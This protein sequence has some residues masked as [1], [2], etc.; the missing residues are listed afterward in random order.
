[1]SIT[2][3]SA[4]F[5][6]PSRKL[7]QL[8]A[9]RRAGRPIHATDLRTTKFYKTKLCP[10]MQNKRGGGRCSEGLDCGYAHAL[11]ELRMAPNLQ[12]TKWCAKVVNGQVCT[13]PKCGYAHCAAELQSSTD[14]QT[15]KT[16]LCVFWSRNP[17]LCLNGSKCRFAH[18]EADLRKRPDLSPRKASP[19][20]HSSPHHLRSWGADSSGRSM[21]PLPRVLKRHSPARRNPA[22]C[23]AVPGAEHG[24]HAELKSSRPT[25]VDR[26]SSDEWQHGT[27]QECFRAKETWQPPALCKR[28]STASEASWSGGCEHHEEADTSEPRISSRR[29]A[30]VSPKTGKELS[31]NREQNSRSRELENTTTDVAEATS[32]TSCGTSTWGASG[33]ELGLPAFPLLPS[34]GIDGNDRTARIA[35]CDTLRVTAP[36]DSCDESRETIPPSAIS[37]TTLVQDPTRITNPGNTAKPEGGDCAIPL[38]A[39]AGLSSRDEKMPVSAGLAE[40]TTK[41]TGALGGGGNLEVTHENPAATT[42][43]AGIRQERN[44]ERQIALYDA[45]KSIDASKAHDAPGAYEAVSSTEDGRRRTARQHASSLNARAPPFIPSSAAHHASWNTLRLEAMTTD[46]SEPSSMNYS[47][48]FRQG[49]VGCDGEKHPQRATGRGPRARNQN[50]PPCR[51]DVCIREKDNPPNTQWRWSRSDGAHRD[52]LLDSVDSERRENVDATSLLLASQ[53]LLKIIA[54]PTTVIGAGRAPEGSTLSGYHSAAFEKAASTNSGT[55]QDGETCYS[56]SRVRHRYTPH[57]GEGI[58]LSKL[59]ERFRIHWGTHSGAYRDSCV[60]SGIASDQ[61]LENRGLIAKDGML[62]ALYSRELFGDCWSSS[63]CPSHSVRFN[64]EI[65]EDS[66]FPSVDKMSRYSTGPGLCAASKETLT[67][68]SA[69]N[70]GGARPL[71]ADEATIRQFLETACSRRNHRFEN[72]VH[73]LA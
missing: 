21:V 70:G 9:T 12:R 39:L 61:H 65:C 15:L 64:E 13:D 60:L 71:T 16:S 37:S 46:V 67:A 27:P 35:A 49:P 38:E 3:D 68:A 53:V 55:N 36:H 8:A 62:Q 18:G 51:G 2:G 66:C 24:L 10:F 29:L 19:L 31:S 63:S 30:T 7:L 28:S 69:S 45:D 17:K 22:P 25:L 20:I 54:S 42:S 34:G 50:G 1:M 11:E 6:P 59:D 4:N 56:A 48:R 23:R 5:L 47:A 33:E 44:S 41:P 40:S 32:G 57:P 72:I 26:S 43:E 58:D 14:K 52:L 73:H